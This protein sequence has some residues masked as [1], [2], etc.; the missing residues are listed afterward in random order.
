LAVL[1]LITVTVLVGG[2]VDDGA[3]LEAAEIEHAHTAIGATAYKNIHT[4]CAESHIEDFFVVCDQLRLGSERGNVPYCA[5]RIYARCDDELRRQG[6]P[7]EGS[8]RRSVFGCFRVREKR[9]GREFG[10]L[11]FSCVDGG[12]PGNG[13]AHSIAR[14]LR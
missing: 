10:K 14:V 9:E 1:T 6:V 3:V 12:R 5:C 4:T 2:L 11:G 7:I 13:V 8:E